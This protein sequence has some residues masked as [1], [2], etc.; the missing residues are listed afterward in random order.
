VFKTWRQPN[1]TAME[2]RIL[3]EDRQWQ[4]NRNGLTALWD[5]SLSML[6]ATLRSGRQYYGVSRFHVAM[7]N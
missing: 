6:V 5:N 1:L 4:Y 7:R 3:I 2:I